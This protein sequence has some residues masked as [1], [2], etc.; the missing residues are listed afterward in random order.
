M[1]SGK[2]NVQ[3]AER[4]IGQRKSLEQRFLCVKEKKPVRVNLC[5][6]GHLLVVAVKAGKKRTVDCGTE[7]YFL[8]GPK[9]AQIWI[10][11]TKIDVK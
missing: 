9:M 4:F 6:L 2:V 3:T 10:C 7:A 1:V 5:Y 8:V 11:W